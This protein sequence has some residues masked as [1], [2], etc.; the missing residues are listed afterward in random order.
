MFERARHFTLLAML[1]NPEFNSRIDKGEKIHESANALT[2]EEFEAAM[3]WVTALQY[4]FKE[5]MNGFQRSGLGP[6]T[7][8]GVSSRYAPTT[9]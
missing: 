1:T 6:K 7:G 8:S 2:E 5:T 3:I 4:E 9:T